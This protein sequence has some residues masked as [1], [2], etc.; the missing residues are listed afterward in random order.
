MTKEEILAILRRKHEAEG[1]NLDKLMLELGRSVYGKIGGNDE[2]LRVC[3][4][5][6]ELRTIANCY[7]RMQVLSIA[8]REVG[9]C[10]PAETPQETVT[11]G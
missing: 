10:A 6:T 8:I 5:R 3:T 7:Q 1:I 11:A 4:I 2:D 9:D